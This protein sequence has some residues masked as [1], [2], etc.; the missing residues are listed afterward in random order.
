ML[1]AVAVVTIT[2]AACGQASKSTSATSSAL[3]SAVAASTE[4]AGTLLCSPAQGQIDACSAKA[5]G[6]ACELTPPSG[7]GAVAGTCRTTIDGTTVACAPNPPAP[8][9]E[10]VDACTGKIAAATC[11]V[12]EPFGDTRDGVCVTAR[13]GATL[14]CGR[15]HTPP[16]A[17]IDACAASAAGAACTMPAHEGTGTVT[18][19][20]S[21]G[22]AS[23]GPLACAPQKDL[24][25]HGEQACIGLAAGATCSLGRGD[26]AVSGTCVTPAAGSAAV[27]VVACADLRGRFE[28]GQGDHGGNGG[29]DGHGGPGGPTGPTGPTGPSGPTGPTEPTGPGMP[30]MPGHGGH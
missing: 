1:A 9:Q 20:C 18:G 26:D 8:P 17:A 22:P 4:A 3:S 27:C 21:L 28:C 19:V 24:L 15:V 30:G 5:A 7:T 6:V 16:Q 2:A 25:P 29:H 14:V 12:T 23:T 13:D 10:L 11:Q